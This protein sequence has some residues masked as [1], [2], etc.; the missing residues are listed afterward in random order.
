MEEAASNRDS[1]SS[2]GT[3]ARLAG[4]RA[5]REQ[6]GMETTIRNVKCPTCKAVTKVDASK[7]HF[8]CHK[9]GEM[10][11][12]PTKF[13]RLKKPPRRLDRNKVVGWVIVAVIAGAA[14]I[15]GVKNSGGSDSDTALDQRTCEIAR[16]IGRSFNVTDTVAESRQRV[17]DLYNGYGSA[18]SRPLL[19]VSDS[20]SLE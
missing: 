5:T 1:T 18:A 9:C 15:A 14:I 17:V 20:G 10:H 8:T 3:S 11:W 4:V 13:D 19:R 16:D 2:R 12:M 6:H 7:S